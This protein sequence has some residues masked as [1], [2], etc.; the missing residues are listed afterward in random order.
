MIPEID[1]ELDFGF[2]LTEVQGLLIRGE[3][4]H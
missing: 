4:Q 3:F 1:C 2:V